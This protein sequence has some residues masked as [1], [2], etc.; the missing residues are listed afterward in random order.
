VNNDYLNDNQ[1]LISQNTFIPHHG[2][3]GYGYQYKADQGV[4][5]QQITMTGIDYGSVSNGGAENND[6]GKETEN[7][8]ESNI[9]LTLKL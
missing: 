3:G 9:D 2:G 8:E 4:V 5:S 6:A 7:E 1:G